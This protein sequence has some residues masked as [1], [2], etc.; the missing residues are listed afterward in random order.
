MM[1]SNL[2]LDKENAKHGEF[3]FAK[4]ILSNGEIRKSPIFVLSNKIDKNE[5]VIICKC[6]GQTSKSQFDVEVQ[7]KEKTYVRTNKIYTIYREQ[8]LFKIPQK[9]SAEEYQKIIQKLKLALKL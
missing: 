2:K 8:L 1:P 9:A 4:F 7:L 6:T 3:F 5:D